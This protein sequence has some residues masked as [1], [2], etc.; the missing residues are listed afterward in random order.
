[1]QNIH[2]VSD[3]GAHFADPREAAESGITI[4]PF[5][6]TIGD[7]TYREGVDL[8]PEEAM[9]QLSGKT[10]PPLLIAPSVED[11]LSVFRRIG[12][13]CDGI[14]SIH[15]SRELSDSWKNARAAAEQLTGQCPMLIFDSQ[16][17]SVA[18][19][20]I[21]NVACEAVRHSDTL[22][23]VVTLLRA[24]VEHIYSVFYVENT[25]F[26]LHNQIMEPAHA[27][28]SSMLVMKPL[29]TI[30]NGRFVPM[31]KVRTRAQ[32]IERLVEF[33]VE[34]TAVVDAQIAQNRHGSSE[35]TRMLQE[36][37]A[38]ELPSLK[39]TQTIFGASLAA[40]I[41]TSATGLIILEG[42]E[43]RTEEDDL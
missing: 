33:A 24:A 41:G 39:P 21:V 26:L 32:A 38:T 30:E 2:I 3:S 29:I 1:M 36:R 13:D 27:I 11:Y 14:V 5:R 18:Q 22:D 35:I 9:R 42:E 25:D 6:L 12:T 28:L 15:M 4:V 19:A 17:I 8:P 43:D 23:D 34:F 31:E 40:F 20:M 16:T 37:L 7:R 10:R